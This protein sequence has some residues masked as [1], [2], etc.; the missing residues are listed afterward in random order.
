MPHFNRGVQEGSLKPFHGPLQAAFGWYETVNDECTSMRRYDLGG[1]PVDWSMPRP[2]Y[3]LV[4]CLPHAHYF[5][6]HVEHDGLSGNRSQWVPIPFASPTNIYVSAFFAAQG[7]GVGYNQRRDEIGLDILRRTYSLD[8][9][10]APTLSCHPGTRREVLDILYAWAS[11]I[12]STT[13]SILWLQGPAGVGKSS[14]LGTLAQRLHATGRLGARFVFRRQHSPRKNAHAFFC[15]LAYQLAINIP[16]LRTPISR[17]VVMNSGIVGESMDVQF[18][19][20][21]LRPCR[22]EMLSHPLILIVDGLDEFAHDAQRE[23][24]TLLSNAAQTRPS[25][26][27]ILVA[28]RL[29]QHTAKIF[30]EPYFNDLCQ[31]FNVQP[32]LEDV[33]LYLWIELARITDNFAAPVSW[34]S[35]QVLEALVEASSGCFLYASTLIRFLVDVDFS[36]T[37]RLAAIE[38]YPLDRLNSSLDQLYTQ[39]L[40]AVP[41]TLRLSLLAFLHI[42]TTKDFTVLPLYRIEQLLRMT[43]GRLR[44]ILRHLRSVLNVL[45]S[46]TGIAAHHVTFLDF[47]ADPARSGAF[48]VSGAERSMYLASCIL[49][50]LAYAHQDPRVNRVGHISWNHLAVMVDY[51][52]SVHPS[53]DFLPLIKYINPDF[54]F[55]SLSTFKQAGNKMLTWLNIENASTADCRD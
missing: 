34:L 29:N 48:C 39:I 21:I 45:P 35:P 37:K 32:S 4:H 24:L 31:S 10:S 14:I 25:P 33:R 42:L 43:P 53:P 52:T 16:H 3:P 41:M 49:E 23:I 19:E 28:S 1:S 46:K 51:V 38:S 27:R 15:T 44:R 26:F 47:L 12:A 5:S 18:Q 8:S 30:A 22:D 54:F 36:P 20:L 2:S 6:P 50:S 9:P 40:A 11:D 55:G 7:S 17:A 13:G